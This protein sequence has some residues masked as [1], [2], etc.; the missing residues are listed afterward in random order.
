LS[1]I[2][3]GI[4]LTVAVELAKQFDIP[5]I[6]RELTTDDVA[7]AEE[8]LLTSTPLC[9]LPVTQLN[10]RPIGLGRPGEVFR[11]LIGAW[12]EMVGVD[13]VAQAEQFSARNA[14]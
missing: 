11:R 9:L 2:L 10:G 13:I 3:R 14:E 6:H 12:S 7:S 5:S 8:V 1:K 4:S